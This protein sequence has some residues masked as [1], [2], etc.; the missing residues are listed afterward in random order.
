MSWPLE[1]KKQIQEGAKLLG[2]NTSNVALVGSILYL[3]VKAYESRGGRF[4]VEMPDGSR[5]DFL[6][7]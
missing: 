2:M 3:R 7:S 4:Y 5:K 6:V 1:K